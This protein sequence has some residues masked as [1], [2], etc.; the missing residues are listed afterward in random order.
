MKHVHRSL[1]KALNQKETSQCGSTEELLQE[2]EMEEVHWLL[3]IPGECQAPEVPVGGESL[4]AGLTGSAGVV[5]AV[6]GASGFGVR[7]ASG[8]SVVPEVITPPPVEENG[9]RRSRRTTVGHHSNVHHLP[10]AVGEEVSDV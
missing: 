3:V 10:R 5:P 2:E 8:P 4:S 9:V 1:L 6:S 7:R